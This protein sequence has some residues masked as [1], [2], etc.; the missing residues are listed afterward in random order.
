MQL[1]RLMQLKRQP[2]KKKKDNLRLYEVAELKWNPFSGG[3]RAWR[4]QASN[5]P[6]LTPK[7]HPSGKIF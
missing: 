5:T 7:L 2:K 1:K 3:Y 4:A 6:L